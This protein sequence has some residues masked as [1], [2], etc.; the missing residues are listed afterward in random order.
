M[1]RASDDAGQASVEFVVLL[2]LLVMVAAA[3][4]QAALAGQAV[5]ASANAARAAAR[6]EAVGGDPAAGARGALPALLRRNLHVDARRT[7]VRVD[8]SIPLVL[9]G[10][11]LAT[12][13]ARAALPPQR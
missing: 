1:P 7:G 2:P 9:T 12:V 11:H 3:L 4:W 8:V 5:W 13:S 10:D 6:A